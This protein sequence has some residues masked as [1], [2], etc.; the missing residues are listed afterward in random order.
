MSRFVRDGGEEKLKYMMRFEE[1]EGRDS[2]IIGVFRIR[3]FG[4]KEEGK[5]RG[6]DEA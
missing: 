1:E 5:I 3:G 4:E 6:Y 2:Q